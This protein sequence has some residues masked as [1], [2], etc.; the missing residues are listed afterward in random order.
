MSWF[1]GLLEDLLMTDLPLSTLTS[2][3]V[4]LTPPGWLCLCVRVRGGKANLH[5][6]VLEQHLMFFAEH[7]SPREEVKTRKKQDRKASSMSADFYFCYCRL[8]KQI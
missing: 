6:P 7:Q 2:L 8:N 5:R 1:S 3:V 4:V